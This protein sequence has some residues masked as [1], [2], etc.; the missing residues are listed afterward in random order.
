MKKILQLFILLSIQTTVAQSVTLLPNSVSSNAITTT[1][2]RVGVNIATPNTELHLHRNSN[3]GVQMQFSNGSTG[4][5][6]NQGLWFGI[7]ADGNAELI[8][9]SPNKDFSIS[10]EQQKK[11]YFTDDSFL[12]SNSI[13]S[14]KRIVVDDTTSTFADSKFSIGVNS[15]KNHAGLFLSSSNVYGRNDFYLTKYSHEVV[16]VI[17][18]MSMANSTVFENDAPTGL[19]LGNYVFLNQPIISLGNSSTSKIMPSQVAV[20]VAHNYQPV[21]NFEVNGTS[22]LGTNGTA[23]TAINNVT[24]IVDLPSISA[25]SSY[26]QTFSISNLP[27]GSNSVYVSPSN[28][29][30]D[31]IIIAFARVS[32]NNT[33]EVK[34]TNVSANA[35][36]LPVNTFYITVVTY[37]SNLN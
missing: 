13:I 8:N 3:V 9:K 33:V 30:T 32:A 20:N 24:H 6:T 5:A 35:I 1:A 25:G 28:N 31:G 27:K 2:N 34:F 36:D 15:P 21:H 22:K 37:P 12:T 17:G 4:S 19:S 26:S 10:I 18:G 16:R 29:L 14:K 7:D 23:I 11:Y